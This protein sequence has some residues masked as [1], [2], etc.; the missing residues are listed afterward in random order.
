MATNTTYTDI[1]YTDPINRT[2]VYLVLSVVLALGIVVVHFFYS[3]ADIH[4]WLNSNHTAWQDIIWQYYTYVGEWVPYAVAA[5]LLLFR[6][7]DGLLLLADL[8][9]SGLAAQ[10]VKHIACTDRPYMY[11]AKHFPDIDLPF[12]DGVR[13]SRF[14]SF[15]SGHT[16]TFFVLMF[17]LAVIITEAYSRRQAMEKDKRHRPSGDVFC[18]AVCLVCF[19]LAA[20]GAYSRIYLSQHFLEDIFGGIVIGVSSTL[21]LLPVASRLQVKPWW[22]WGLIKV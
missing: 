18:A 13:L 9:L 15:P 7:G 11:F 22:S 10:A 19:L 8:A 3:K 14:F 20:A 16:T 17:V 12:V 2:S 4:L 21:L 5:V 1:A 6:F